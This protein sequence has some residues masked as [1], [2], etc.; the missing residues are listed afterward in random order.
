MLFISSSYAD[1]SVEISLDKHEFL[2]AE[3][4]FYHI[5]FINNSNSID[6]INYF[7][8]NEYYNQLVVSGTAG[9]EIFRGGRIMTSDFYGKIPVIN[10]GANDTIERSQNLLDVAGNIKLRYVLHGAEMYLSQGIYKLKYSYGNQYESNELIINIQKA[11]DKEEE[12]FRK[13]L[14]GYMIDDGKPWRMDSILFKKDTYYEIALNYPESIYWEEAV[15]RYNEE[16]NYLK[17]D[18][19]D[20][21]VN[22]EFVKRYPDSYIIRNILINVCQAIYYYGGGK[23]A[24]DFYLSYLIENFQNY[25]VFDCAKEQMEKKEYLN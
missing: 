23:P 16:S 10:I 17:L 7:A 24:V 19:K 13:L 1:V 6:S 15:Y 4:I 9:K 12:V 2:E 22:K 14:K 5:K 25:R 20:I 8:L 21:N 18:Y 3:P 11:Q